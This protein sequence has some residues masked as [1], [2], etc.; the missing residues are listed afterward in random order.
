MLEKVVYKKF[1][2]DIFI[3]SKIARG[4]KEVRT[5]YCVLSADDDFLLPDALKQALVFLSTH[6]GYSCVHGDSLVHSLE[7]VDG[8]WEFRVWPLRLGLPSMEDDTPGRRLKRFFPFRYVGQIFYAVQR[9]GTLQHIWSATES[10]VQ[11]WGLSEIVP[12]CLSVIFGK[13]KVLPIFYVSR[14]INLYAETVSKSRFLE[15]GPNG[16]KILDR[17]IEKGILEETFSTELRLKQKAGIKEEVIRDIAKNDFDDIWFILQ[18]SFNTWVGTREAEWYTPQRISSAITVL[19]EA[20]AEKKDRSLSR[21]SVEQ[22]FRQYM[23][24]W[25]RQYYSP[26]PKTMMDRLVHKFRNHFWFKRIRKAFMEDHG[27]QQVREAV[28]SAHIDPRA[29]DVSRATYMK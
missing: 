19:M 1:P 26:H 15:L 4:L 27:L 17:L 16:G 21:K 25:G 11:Y 2:R 29:I 9:S 20:L 24:L 18:H 3:T 23:E 8:K 12:V 10:R 6:N 13:V 14:E 5:E 7:E 28:L 22:L